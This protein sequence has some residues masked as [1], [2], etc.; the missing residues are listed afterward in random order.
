MSTL[1]EARAIDG[2][3]AELKRLLGTRANDHAAVREHHSHGESYHPPALPDVVC[4][5]A[6]TAEVVAIVEVSRRFQVPVIPFGAG[7]SLEGHV[8]ALRGGITIDLRDMN[9]V[10]RVSTEDLDATVEAGVTRLQLAKALRN[11]GLAFPIDPGADAT[12]GGMAATRAS[13]T[14]AVRYGTMRENVLGLTAVLAD[15]RVIRT[16][17]RARKSSAGYDLT[18]LFVGSEGTLGVI[19]DVTLR[20]HPVPEAVSAAICAFGSIQGAVDTVI[21]TIQQGVPVARIELLDDVQIDAINRYSKTAYRVAPTLLFEFHGDSER[22]V[23]DQAA[24]VAAVAAEHGGQDFDWATRLEDRERLWQARH[25]AHYAGLALRPGC[26]SWATDVCVP[27]S[28]LADCIQE[29][30]ADHAQLPFPVC[31]VGHAGDGNFHLMYLLDPDSPAELAE[32]R[33][34]NDRLVTRALAMGGTCTGEH[35]VGYG[36]MAYL[37]AEHGE[38]LEVMRAIKLALDPDNRMNPGKI[39]NV[40]G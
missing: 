31:L 14:T 17:T 10:L 25:N 11:T 16:G 28:R 32:A 15:G 7:T 24:V 4:F 20:L 6:S 18:R 40:D 21:A 33:R 1:P 2:A 27:I 22:H 12:I 5:P 34:L 13:G 30:K 29:T 36:K 26:R 39:V 38:G 37:A 3:I 23:A 8:H 19:T 9:H 35:G